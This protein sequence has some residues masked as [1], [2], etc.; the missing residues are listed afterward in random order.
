[1]ADDPIPE[2]E[3]GGWQENRRRPEL[4]VDW[5]GLAGWLS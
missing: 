2:M 5:G 1:M 4:H 3:K